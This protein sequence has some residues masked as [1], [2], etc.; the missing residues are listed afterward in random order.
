MAETLADYLSSLDEISRRQMIHA[1]SR[2]AEEMFPAE[3][4]V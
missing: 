3:W 4:K 2:L 1:M